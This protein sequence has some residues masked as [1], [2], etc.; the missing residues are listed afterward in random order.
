MC[1]EFFA[2]REFA[3]KGNLWIKVHPRLLN[4]LDEARR[5]T[6]AIAIVSGYRDPAH[7]KRVGGASNSQHVNGTAADI[8]PGLP[9]DLAREL[10][11]SGIGLDGKTAI[12]VDVRGEGPNNTTGGRPGN[13]TIWY[14]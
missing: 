3:S 12:H 9:V 6:G 13:P 8:R 14:Y 7:N 10:G 11:F 2:F 1:A 4:R 5:R